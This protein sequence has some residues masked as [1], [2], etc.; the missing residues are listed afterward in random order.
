MVSVIMSVYNGQKHL[1]EAIESILAQTVRDYEFI[2]IDDASKDDSLK[3][4]E[5]YAKKDGRI[6]IIR[7]EEN[8]GLTKSLNKA[9]KQAKGEYI[10]RQ[11]A[12]DFSKKNRL[13]LQLRF[14][15]K[16]KD[17]FLC[18]TGYSI[19]DDSSELIGSISGKREPAN[20]EK[21]LKKMNCLCTSVFFR[22]DKKTFYREKFVYSQ[23]YD[24]YL[25]L[26]SRGKKLA[27]MKEILYN[28]RL[29]DS[30][31]TSRH[32]KA[33]F[34]FSRKARE[35]YLER[36]KFKK[37]SYDDFNPEGIIKLDEKA[38]D[39]IFTDYLTIIALIGT[40]KR[41]ARKKILSVM[42]KRRKISLLLIRSL[43][44]TFIPSLKYK[45][46]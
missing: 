12:D 25:L 24:F 15:E 3:I 38:G 27:N 44:K 18:G 43:I 6:K 22:H 1:R 46:T 26:L 33:Q 9:L 30:A 34:L 37:D 13:E 32:G 17:I 35:F 42:I 19:V 21:T 8:I 39:F 2:I 4:T 45:K 40:D 20:V 23:D 5:E 16:N 14:L 41:A 31:I 36:L 7:N 10:A 29:S 28:Y 11:D